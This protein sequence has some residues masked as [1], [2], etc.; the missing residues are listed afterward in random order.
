VRP[1][2]DLDHTACADW[3]AVDAIPGE[4]RDAL[5]IVTGSTAGAGL[6]TFRALR[7]RASLLTRQ[8]FARKPK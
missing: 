1:A 3:T 4:D 7:M 2:T 6:T 5:A 8:A